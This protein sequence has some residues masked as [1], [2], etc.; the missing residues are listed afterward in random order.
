[1]S[2]VRGRSPDE[3]VRR[4]SAAASTSSRTAC[5]NFRSSTRSTVKPALGVEGRKVILSFGLL[6]PGKGYEL[7]LAALPDVVA[8]HPSAL[9]VVVGAT[10]PD[11]LR[12]QGEAYREGLVAT[13]ARLGLQDHVRF[14]DRFVG[15]VELTKWLEAADVFVTPYPNLDQIVSGTLSYAMGAGR[16]IVST[17]YAYASELLADGRGVLVPPASPAALGGR[18]ERAPRRSRPA[19]RDRQPGLRLQPADGLVGGRDEYADLFAVAWPAARPHERADPAPA[20]RR[21]CLTSHRSIRQ[22]AAP[23]CHDRRRRDH[24]ARDR[25]PA[26]PGARLLRRRRGSRP[27]GRPAPRERAGLG[28]GGADRLASDAR[29]STR[30]STR[31]AAA[32]GTSGS[33]DGAW[34]G[35]L[36]SD[37]SYGRAM[38]A[39]GDVIATAPDAAAGRRRDGAPR[40]ER[41][42]QPATS[43][44]PRAEAS[45]VLGC[46]ADPASPLRADAPARDAHA[47]RDADCTT[48]S[49]AARRPTGRGRKCR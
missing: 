35:G 4:R 7:A 31:T 8:A 43:R 48:G 1:M 20:G 3:R 16:A 34:I 22:P 17:P 46:A 26:R 47:P 9:Y 6:G 14:V 21:R 11:L 19:G 41:C 32:S 25:V 36:G 27:P 37:D 23:R 29:S 38:L 10:H 24:A 39:L 12:S 28:G 13:V 42:R 2:Q 5:P 44:S 45:V 49:G 18:A 30:R 33:I 15:R 40:P